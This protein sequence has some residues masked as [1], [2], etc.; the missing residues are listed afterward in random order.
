MMTS[1]PHAKV[2]LK[3]L[4]H[5]MNILFDVLKI[6]SILHAP[7]ILNFSGCLFGKKCKYKDFACF[8]ETLANYFL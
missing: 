6:K 4:S 8:Y 2:V 1:R 5:E 7:L 3:R